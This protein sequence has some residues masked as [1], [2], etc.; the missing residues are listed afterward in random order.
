MGQKDLGNLLDTLVNSLILSSFSA[1]EFQSRIQLCT[2][3]LHTHLAIA[4]AR[5][6]AES[7]KPSEGTND[8]L[9][10]RS[11]RCSSLS[12]GR[13][14]GIGLRTRGGG[15]AGTGLSGVRGGGS[16]GQRAL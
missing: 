3:C 5:Q 16:G 4:P 6:R 9:L 15:G 7:S 11:M 10:L 13:G 2:L 14:R 8:R 1:T 12:W